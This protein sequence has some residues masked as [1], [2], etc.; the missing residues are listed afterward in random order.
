M[1]GWAGFALNKSS[2]SKG[3]NGA[4]TTQSIDLCIYY[5]IF[6]EDGSK[7]SCPNKSQYIGVY[8]SY[9]WKCL[10]GALFPN[11]Q[12][13]CISGGGCF[14]LVPWVLRSPCVN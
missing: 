10:E 12:E 3:K 14:Q 9:T 5:E 8:F 13:G 11:L 1:H 7:S 6:P 2:I 4:I